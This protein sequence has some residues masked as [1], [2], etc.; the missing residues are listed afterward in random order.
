[1]PGN[2][3]ATPKENQDYYYSNVH[4][5]LQKGIA[6]AGVFDGHGENG[7]HVSNFAAKQ[8][9]MYIIEDYLKRNKTEGSLFDIRESIAF[10]VARMEA[11]L[12]TTGVN[13]SASGSTAIFAVRISNTLYVCNIGD[14]RCILGRRNMHGAIEAFA[15][16]RDHKPDERSEM[17][18][19]TSM[20]GLVEPSRNQFGQFIG[21]ARVWVPG[22]HDVGGLAIGRTI[23]DTSYTAVGVVS[24]PEISVHDISENDVFVVLASDGIWDRLSNSE[25]VD[26]VRQN[27]PA[28]KLN[29]PS[30]GFSKDECRKAAAALTKTAQSRW[31][32][33]RGGWYVDDIT[34][35]VWCL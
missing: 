18:R 6:V 28:K 5:F 4:E 30:N 15:L 34:A 3:I 23:G 8:I 22:K 20:G 2:S 17:E 21:P 29:A 16:S 31:R 25:V 26:I 13:V 14:S 7:K 33:C 35:M 24:T 19:I 32:S 1:M 10:A 27:L 12:G 11:E 9:P